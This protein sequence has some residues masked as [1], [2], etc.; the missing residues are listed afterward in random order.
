[1]TSVLIA[2]SFTILLISGVV[3]FVSPPGRIANWTNWTILGLRKQE[4]TALHIW[5][6]TAFLFVTGFHVFF[7]WRPLLNYFKDRISRRFGFR[8]EWF[9]A[10]AICG[11]VY[12]GTRAQIPPFS[13]LMAFNEGV[14]E[15]WDKPKER[16][17][18]P[19]AE[20]LSLQELS[21]KA[22]VEMTV[23]TNR[24]KGRN[25]TNFSPEVIVQKLA[26]DN[27]RSAQSIYEAI[28]G[29]A[30]P[31]RPGAGH[32]G[33][34][35]RGKAGAGG[36][37]GPGWKT[38]TQYCADEGM[39]LKDALAKLQAKGIKATPDQTM[40]EIAVNNGYERPYELIDLLKSSK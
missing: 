21:E 37:G 16:A 27:Q 4:W 7:N 19:H 10:F 8:R 28:Q 11:G 12:A 5:F 18:I 31:A 17:P 32:S 24:L 6:S 2:C 3:L 34:Q 23:V 40:R 13:S 25:I 39:D 20:L 30:E 1:M 33:G 38:L 36:G 35:G 29:N 15:S 22:G 14:K 26:D 9:V